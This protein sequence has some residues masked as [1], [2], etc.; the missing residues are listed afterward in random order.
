MLSENYRFE[1]LSFREFIA[2]GEL[3]FRGYVVKWNGPIQGIEY[4]ITAVS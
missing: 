4:K 2:C 1:R 3:K